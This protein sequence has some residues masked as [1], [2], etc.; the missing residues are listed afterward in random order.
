MKLDLITI[1]FMVG[2]IYITVLLMDGVSLFL[3]EVVLRI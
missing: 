3:L 1:Q 2:K